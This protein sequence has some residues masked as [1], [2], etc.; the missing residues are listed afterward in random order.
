MLRGRQRIDYPRRDPLCPRRTWGLT[1]SGIETSYPAFG[2]ENLT[3]TVD[4]TAGR[5]MSVGR[6][7]R[8][9]S[10]SNIR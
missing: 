9:G 6:G 2:L 5:R 10:T 1:D 7:L 4:W 8:C 3:K